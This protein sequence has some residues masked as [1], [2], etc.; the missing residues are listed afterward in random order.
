MYFDPIY[1]M[2]M[3]IGLPLIL[4]PQWYVKS[5]Y[6]KYNKVKSGS[7]KTGKQVAE[8]LLRINDLA[9]TVEVK[10]CAGELTDHYDP[11]TNTVNLSEAIYFGDSV[12]AVSI[13]AHEVGHAIQN[14][15]SYAP[16]KF[17]SA[18]FPVASIG[19]KLGGL[20][21]FG[22]LIMMFFL[23][24]PGLGMPVAIA[25]LLLYSAIVLFQI[26]TLPVEFNASSRALKLFKQ[27]NIVPAAELAI[28]RKVLNA[29][30]LTYVAAALY[31]ILNLAYYAYLIF[32]RRD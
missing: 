9:Q 31:A 28:S 15:T 16:I 18:F 21:L 1:I 10:P 13:A 32:Y 20:M 7:A 4:I 24:M 17:R 8:E 3:L 23:G 5:T 22:G 6:K 14:N 19:D 26:I 12:S 11:R 27:Y 30:A 2:I 25:G 29:A